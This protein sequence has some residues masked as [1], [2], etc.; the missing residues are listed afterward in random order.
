MNI[1]GVGGNLGKL[2]RA[3]QSLYDDNRMCV[4]VW[5]EKSVWLESKVSFKARLC[6]VSLVIHHMHGWCSQGGVC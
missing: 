6:D 1:F 3:L 2:L 4:R 5:G